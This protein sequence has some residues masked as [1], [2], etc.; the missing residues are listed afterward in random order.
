MVPLDETT[1]EYTHFYCRLVHDHES[2]HPLDCGTAFL[3]QAHLVFGPYRVKSYTFMTPER[4]IKCDMT[5]V[6]G[7]GE[8]MTT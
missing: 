8:R 5:A 3:I 2:T 1:L 7:S 6:L 4:H